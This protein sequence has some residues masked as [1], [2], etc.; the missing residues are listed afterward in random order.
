MTGT[1]PAAGPSFAYAAA[2]QGH[3]PAVTVVTEAGHGDAEALAATAASLSGQSL[4]AWNWT[5]V[6]PVELAR[7]LDDPRVRIVSGPVRAT[8]IGRMLSE[9]GGDLALVE[10]GT[11]LQ[12]TTLEKWAW[13]LDSNLHATGVAGARRANEPGEPFLLRRSYVEQSGGLDAAYAMAFS[14]DVG[15]VPFTGSLHFDDDPDA[16]PHAWVISTATSNAWISDR[17]PFENRLEKVAPRLLLIAP[18]MILGGADKVNLDVMEQLRAAGWEISVATTLGGHSLLPAYARHTPDLFPLAHFLDLVDFP[19]FL[20]YLI[21]SR[22]FDAVLV[23]NSELG[24]RLL[25]YLRERCPEPAYLD[26]C[27]SEAEH[28]YHGGYPRLSVEYQELLDLTVTASAHL[29]RWMGGHGAELNRI[30]VCHANVDTDAI[31]PDPDARRRVRTR[32]GVDEN[33]PLV[34]FV[35]R[36]SEDKQP[37]VLM[38]AT[39]CLRDRGVP[40]TLV[41]AG[42]GPDLPR[43]RRFFLL[44]G[45]SDRVRLPGVIDHSTIGDLYAAADVLFVPSRSEGIALVLYEAMSAGVPVVGAAVG[46]QAE[47]V[48]PETG[49][50]VPRGTVEEEQERYADALEPLLRDR[51][52][53]VEMGRAA[54]RRIEE[55]FR[56]EQMGTRMAELLQRAIRLRDEEP[57]PTPAPGL[58]RAVA[59]E[60]IELTRPA[61]VSSVSAQGWQNGRPA[62][63]VRIY[64]FLQQIGGPTY[65]LAV[66]HG[67][68]G[69]PG[70]RDALRRRLMGH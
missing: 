21:D 51:E 24:Y 41:V 69:L 13:Y 26:F 5:I 43:L 40:F 46:G 12:P 33:E 36:V 58:A 39:R 63:G 14:S 29:R 35:G 65:R 44:N 45:M 59:T 34:L 70:V 19:R 22:R 10:P 18:W 9:A 32:L 11:I 48:T 57:R 50:L 20:A 7:P 64:L 23:S 55:G 54:R 27:H 56:V 2:E 4:Q 25:P 62:V 68:P 53:R 61:I 60:A 30:A 31:H 8:A 3:T 1:I 66:A 42:D 67:A 47:L 6:S 49:V 17:R 52:L 37:D 16:E 15:Y 38:A 28:W